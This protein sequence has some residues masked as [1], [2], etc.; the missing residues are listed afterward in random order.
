MDSLNT[1]EEIVKILKK[2]KLLFAKRNVRD[3]IF[4]NDLTYFAF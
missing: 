4:L 2:T 3:L 1:E